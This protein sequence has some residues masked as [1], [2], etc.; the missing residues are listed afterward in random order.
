MFRGAE[1]ADNDR[2]FWC[3]KDPNFRECYGREGKDVMKT[4][5][6]YFP[7]LEP[8]D[9]LGL[10]CLAVLAP[11]FVFKVGFALILA[12]KC[13]KVKS[14][15]QEEESMIITPDMMGNEASVRP[16]HQREGS[17]ERK[18]FRDG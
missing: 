15:S 18:A 16:K 4:F 7:H 9:E 5:R 17:S 12:R 1:P 11:G 8:D 2:G 14:L 3:P 10:D 6:V 13:Y